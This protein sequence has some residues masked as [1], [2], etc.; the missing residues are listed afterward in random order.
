[1]KTITH[2]LTPGLLTLTLLFTGCCAHPPSDPPEP[3]ADQAQRI[4]AEITQV[5]HDSADAWT[6]DDLDAFMQS[7]HRSPD[8]TFAIPTGITKGWQPLKDRYASSIDKS[9]LW[10]TDIQVTPLRRDAALVFAR[11]H[12]E[13]DADQSYSTGLTT[14]LMKKIDGRWVITH[15]HS[16][17]LPA[18][19]PRKGPLPS[20]R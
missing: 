3:R 10:F 9:S 16:S 7:F 17:G 14:L 19:T 4:T 11:F 6:N 18:D 5:M 1:M 15:D 13:M 8:L 12:N 2:R 20:Q